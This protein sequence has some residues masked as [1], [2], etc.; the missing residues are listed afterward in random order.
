MRVSLGQILHKLRFCHLERLASHTL[1]SD[2]AKASPEGQ[3][4]AGQRKASCQAWI[5][6]SPA[7]G[8]RAGLPRLALVFAVGLPLGP[9]AAGAIDCGTKNVAEARPRIR[10]T[11]LGHRAL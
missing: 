2:G 9:L 5:D 10:R 1:S 6:L 11:E 7:P 8:W 4:K 3:G